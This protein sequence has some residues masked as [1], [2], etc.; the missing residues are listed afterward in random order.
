M[1]PHYYLKTIIFL[2][3]FLDNNIIVYGQNPVKFDDSNIHAEV[4]SYIAKRCGVEDETGSAIDCGTNIGEWDVSGVTNMSYLFYSA[5]G[6]SSSF[7][8]NLNSWNTSSVTNMA[9]MFKG[10]T[11]FNSDLHWDVSNVVNMNGM[12]SGASSFN[13]DI[14]GWNTSSVENMMFMFADAASFNQDLGAWNISSVKEMHYAFMFASS[15]NQNLCAW[16]DN[17]PYNSATNIF[18]NS[19]CTY[20]STPLWASKGSWKYQKGP[21]CASACS[22]EDSVSCSCS[23]SGCIISFH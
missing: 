5:D 16:A 22:P 3:F 12:F 20:T 19:G 7:N 10:A 14:S 15:Y 13:K 21:F 17:F 9:W 8:Q 2:L 18:F 1:R 6:K 4:D 11:A 23:H